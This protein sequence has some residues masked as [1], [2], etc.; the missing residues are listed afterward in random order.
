MK[1]TQRHLNNIKSV[2]GGLKNWW[3]GK[4]EA[5]TPEKPQRQSGLQQ[6]LDES[7]PSQD[8]R[9]H[10]ALRIRETDTRGFYDEGSR[11]QTQAQARS[12]HW[13]RYESQLDDNLGEKT[14]KVAFLY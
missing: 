11:S 3:S 4:K 14:A 13:Q 5:Q 6:T 7:L 1:T 2:F 8:Q 12:E 10:P 9:E